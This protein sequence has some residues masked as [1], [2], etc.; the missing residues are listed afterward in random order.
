MRLKSLNVDDIL[1]DKANYVA[2]KEARE[3]GTINSQRKVKGVPFPVWWF[4]CAGHGGYIAVVKDSDVAQ[5]PFLQKWTPAQTY[6][7]AGITLFHVYVF[8]EDCAWAVLESFVPEIFD[9][10]YRNWHNPEGKDI[11]TYRIIVNRT[12][13]RWYPEMLA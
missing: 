10:G 13:D 8:E 1:R 9:D 11:A 3:W 4:D 12:I 7:A 2:R 5:Y 6:L